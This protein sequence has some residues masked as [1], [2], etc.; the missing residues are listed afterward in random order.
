MVYVLTA[1]SISSEK[2]GAN[3][4]SSGLAG[5]GGVGNA[6]E[7]TEAGAAAG[8]GLCNL[9]ETIDEEGSEALSTEG[10]ALLRMNA[11]ENRV[12]M[13]GLWGPVPVSPR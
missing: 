3:G 11:C 10:W 9:S 2:P 12:M 4:I 1:S 13:D 8:V 5:I 6:A 7:M